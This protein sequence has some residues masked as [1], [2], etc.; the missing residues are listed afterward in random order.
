[1]IFAVANLASGLALY[2][3]MILAQ[4]VSKILG[5]DKLGDLGTAALSTA[6]AAD[7]SITCSLLFYMNRFRSTV[8]EEDYANRRTLPMINR[9]M[10]YLINVGAVTS[11]TDIV[12][13]VLSDVL[14]HPS[15]LKFYALFEVVGNLYANS[16][17]ATLNARDSLRSI[18]Q[19]DSSITTPRNPTTGLNFA[20]PVNAINNA[21]TSVRL[22]DM[23]SVGRTS[24]KKVIGNDFTFDLSQDST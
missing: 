24:M 20:H 21:G 17:L 23:S 11:L 14:I 10:F 15:N 8:S 18:S 19:V 12:T 2:A 9:L 22:E 16:L 4:K 5:S 13:L 3:K 1:M 6:I 7:I